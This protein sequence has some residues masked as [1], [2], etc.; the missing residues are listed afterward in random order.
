LSFCIKSTSR[1]GP[2]LTLARRS[3]TNPTGPYDG[4]AR[5]AWVDV[6]LRSTLKMKR[7]GREQDYAF[8]AI[9]LAPPF[10]R[11]KERCRTH[12]AEM[13]RQDGEFCPANLQPLLDR[14]N[15]LEMPQ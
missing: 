14:L 12:R 1:Y 7:Y 13:I 5:K 10:D 2:R 3:S 15:A 9:Y 11:R 6:K 4:A 8:H